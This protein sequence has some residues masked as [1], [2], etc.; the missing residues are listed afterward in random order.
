MAG[1]AN[2]NAKKVRLAIL[3]AN[4]LL[5]FAAEKLG[6]SRQTV[7]NWVEKSAICAAAVQEARDRFDDVGENQFHK[8][9]REGKPWA[10][11]KWVDKKGH[12]RGYLDRQHIEHSGEGGGP[13]VMEFVVNDGKKRD[14]TADQPS[15]EAG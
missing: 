14:K 12:K 5:S 10:V 2:L 9:V 8:A 15:A 11:S 13:L 7:Y 6:V 4:G 3:S 1:T